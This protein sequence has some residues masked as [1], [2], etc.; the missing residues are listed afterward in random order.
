M[1]IKLIFEK[2]QG[3]SL[4][5]NYQYAVSSWIYKVLQTGDKEFSAWLHDYGY[6][7]G[8]K[9]FK[10]FTFSNLH[11]D[12]CKIDRDKISILSAKT[13]LQLSFYPMKSLETFIQ[14]VFKDQEFEIKTRKG[15]VKFRVTGVEKEKEMEFTDE[16]DF[17]LRT[18]I[19][20]IEHNPY[21]EDKI[22][23]LHPDHKNFERLFLKNLIDKYASLHPEALDNLITP[24]LKVLSEP[25][26]KLI[27]I[28]E[29]TKQ[30]T[31]LRG[32]VFDF[33]VKAHP[34]LL[35]TGYYA[36][37]GKSNPMGFGFADII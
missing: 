14:G 20:I 27:T 26:P 33:S 37:F 34:K 6:R 24:K 18:P 28:K 29:G 16:M 7:N 22:D 5:F 25:K 21:H 35:Q 1:R 32:F 4:S 17:R 11:F 19:H 30:E 3:T 8:F 2:L 12:D 36:G 15:N 9:Q 31:K 13:S 23:H 10:L